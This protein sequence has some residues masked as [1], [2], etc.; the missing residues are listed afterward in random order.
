MI[1]FYEC[2]DCGEWFS[3]VIGSN[4]PAKNCP[5]CHSKNVRRISRKVENP[6]AT[7]YYQYIKE[8]KK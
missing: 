8:K 7:P 2:R 1:R 4:N 3:M 6:G 5:Y